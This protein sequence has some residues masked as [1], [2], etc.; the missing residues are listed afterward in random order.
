M[1]TIHLLI[2]GK[3]Q[4]VFYRTSA[5]ETADT[6][7]LTGWIRNTRE[8]DVEVMVTGEA[9]QLQK[10]ESWCKQGPGGAKVRHMTVTKQ[11][12]TPFDDFTICRGW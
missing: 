7:G 5:R 12:E 2:K 6:L 4:G 11:E 9:A 10:F 3:V 8:G 1:P